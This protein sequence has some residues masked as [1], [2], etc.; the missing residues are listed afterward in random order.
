[1]NTKP[2]HFAQVF[3]RAMSANKPKPN[4]SRQDAR[5]SNLLHSISGGSFRNLID[6]TRDCNALEKLKQELANS[7][8]FGFMKELLEEPI[9]EELLPEGMRLMK[10]R[11]IVFNLCVV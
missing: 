5:F 7:R 2:K 9:D 6:E 8:E 11:K 4:H 3:T 1:M 10:N